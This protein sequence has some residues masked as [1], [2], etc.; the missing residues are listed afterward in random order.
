MTSQTTSSDSLPAPF[1]RSRAYFR[2]PLASFITSPSSHQLL[3]YKLGVFFLVAVLAGH[4]LVWHGPFLR[5]HLA[6]YFTYSLHLVFTY[7]LGLALAMLAFRSLLPGWSAYERRTVGQQWCMWGVGFCLGYLLHRLVAVEHIDYYAPW[8]ADYLRHRPDE[9][10]TLL[11]LFVFSGLAWTVACFAAI[12]T[13]MLLHKWSEANKPMPEPAAPS[14]AAPAPAAARPSAPPT[15]S[16]QHDGTLSRIPLAN[17]THVTVEDHYCRIHFVDQEGP[18]NVF[19]CMPLKNLKQKLPASGF[20]QIHRS[21]L[22][23]LAQVTEVKRSGRRYL[24]VLAAARVEL[25][26]SRQRWS[27]LRRRLPEAPLQK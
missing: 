11:E 1:G 27:E 20:T 3:Y 18:R 8:L 2:R 6:F 12:Q 13:A 5:A 25:P 10:P 9:T 15:L 22:V 16:V 7:M 24:A 21:H 14:S 17:I 26:I 4:A 23:N 19:V